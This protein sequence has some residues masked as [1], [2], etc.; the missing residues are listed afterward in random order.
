[1]W[2]LEHSGEPALGVTLG[3]A[4]LA[5]AETFV[6]SVASEHTARVDGLVEI[7]VGCSGAVRSRDRGAK[8]AILAVGRIGVG[9]GLGCSEFFCP[10]DLLHPFFGRIL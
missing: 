3:E 2:I 6:V 8:P 7:E 9:D 4:V 1:M 10:I 5:T